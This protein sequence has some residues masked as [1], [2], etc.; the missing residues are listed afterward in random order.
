MKK[1]NSILLLICLSMCIFILSCTQKQ[2]WPQFRGPE[3]NMVAPGKNLPAE[4][5]NDKNIKWKYK[6]EGFGWSSPIVWGN[7]V[8]I[9][10][11]IPEKLVSEPM[12]QNLSTIVEEEER[13][14]TVVVAG[15]PPPRPPRPPQDTT[16]FLKDTYRW[17][18]TCINLN[19]GKEL[20]KQVAYNGNPRVKK[21]SLNGYASETPVTDGKRLYVYFG[22]T[23]IFCYDLDGKFLWKKD[24]GAYKTQNGWGTGSSPVIYKDILYIQNDNEQNSFLIAIDAATGDEKWRVERNE[25]TN[26]TTPFIWKNKVREELVTLGKT[27]RSYDLKT[28]NLLWEMKA[29][30][31]QSIPSPVADENRIYL[32]NAGG[33]EVKSNLFAIK[34]GATGD[35][36]PKDSIS[37]NNWI[38]WSFPNANPGNSSP[39]LYKG[40]L[41]F[42]GSEGRAF[43]CLNSADGK[44]VYKTS[45]KALAE[46]WASPWAYDDKICF[47]DERGVTRIIK[48]GEKFELLSENRLKDRFWASPAIT[49]NS[50]IFK[51]V[52]FLYCI[53]N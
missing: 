22:M 10:A 16:G 29:G 7:K 24:I 12:P 2:N 44:Q 21:H 8:F 48:A 31:E 19:T 46:T 51:G 20:W 15:P 28:G 14:D 47:Y 25:K 39:L 53:R 4:W 1:T 40:L 36:T 49:D 43:T 26:Y 33:R 37:L 52:D 27:F 5:G 17:E 9:V 30:G 45:I 32:A 41:Y 35:I 13:E 38:E 18:V 11:S 50:Y 6:I 34:A 42:L 3:S 23:G